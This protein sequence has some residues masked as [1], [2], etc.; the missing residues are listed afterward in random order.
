MNSFLILYNIRV[1]II[2]PI[3]RILNEYSVLSRKRPEY[4]SMIRYSQQ[5][6]RSKLVATSWPM[7]KES[8]SG[9]VKTNQLAAFLKHPW[10]LSITN[11]YLISK[12]S[13]YQPKYPNLR[14]IFHAV[15]HQEFYT[16]KSSD[17]LSELKTWNW[18]QYHFRQY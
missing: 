7:N 10:W 13:L 17:Y 6:I 9:Y 16:Y 8:S 5:S 4:F 12:S 1:F 11:V 18:I 2:I 14:K 15:P 3:F